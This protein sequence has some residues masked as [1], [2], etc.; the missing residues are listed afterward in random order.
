MLH[1][2]GDVILSPL[3]KP[4]S[5]LNGAAVIHSPFWHIPCSHHFFLSFFFLFSPFSLLFFFVFF[6]LLLHTDQAPENQVD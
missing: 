6:L 2:K 5:S 1:A 3:L 4:S